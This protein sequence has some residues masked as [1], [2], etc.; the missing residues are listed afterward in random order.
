[1]SSNTLRAVPEGP[2]PAYNPSD[3][4]IALTEPTASGGDVLHPLIGKIS[5]FLTVRVLKK[6]ERSEAVDGISK[7]MSGLRRKY[8]SVLRSRGLEKLATS[9]ER[10]EGIYDAVEICR[11]IEGE[12]NRALVHEELAHIRDEATA[13][14]L[15][16]FGFLPSD[17][18]TRDEEA[19]QSDESAENG[20]AHVFLREL[21]PAWFRPEY[22]SK[23]FKLLPQ[24]APA[25]LP[26]YQKFA[27]LAQWIEEVTGEFDEAI[28]Q[29][30]LYLKKNILPA[31]APE[32]PAGQAWEPVEDLSTQSLVALFE[33]VL[34]A[35]MSLRRRFEAFRLLEWS[36]ALFSIKRNPIFK[37]QQQ[38]RRAL[39]SQ[40]QLEIWE[41]RTKISAMSVREDLVRQVEE[42][43]TG[44][45]S[46][47][48]T[49]KYTSRKIDQEFQDLFNRYRDNVIDEAA[50]DRVVFSSREKDAE[51]S[52]LKI[53]LLQEMVAKSFATLSGK[54]TGITKKAAFEYLGKLRQRSIKRGRSGKDFRDKPVGF[55]TLDDQVGFT[56]AVNLRKRLD[57][58]SES[59]KPAV[60]EFFTEFA[61]KLGN[62]LRLRGVEVENFLWNHN[63]D[64]PR[65]H[66]EFRIFKLHGT[67]PIETDVFVEGGVAKKI[68][69]IPVEIQLHPM[70]SNIRT[71]FDGPTGKNAY[72]KRK[73]GDVAGGLAPKYIGPKKVYPTDPELD[74]L[75][76]LLNER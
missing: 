58:Y 54:D 29:A 35:K 9:V 42:E 28:N 70:E 15:A 53:F 51:S 41:S 59:D 55:D 30:Y 32:G 6:R 11:N 63:S 33:T 68:V 18:F 61:M 48:A 67:C 7:V 75:E 3:Q 74:A 45:K 46:G 62:L 25:N 2:K 73:A 13:D 72:G 64:N 44:T 50:T 38:V 69:D 10:S 8:A 26:T 21:F 27:Q 39:H 14:I 19:A 12:D 37:A 5:P 60:D 16:C 4:Y 65:S 52:A 49:T 17:V 36:F 20:E 76:Q 71:R 66:G 56:L 40:L 47:R 23:P 22:F 24:V 31:L 43:E 34:D 1:M 57:E